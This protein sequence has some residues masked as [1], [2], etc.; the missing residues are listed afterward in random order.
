MS[1]Y[2][3]IEILKEYTKRIESFAKHQGLIP[4]A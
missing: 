4:S 2:Q 1:A 3:I